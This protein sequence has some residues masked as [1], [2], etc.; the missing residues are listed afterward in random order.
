MLRVEREDRLRTIYS[1]HFLVV[2]VYEGAVDSW[3]RAGVHTHVAGAINLK[4]PGEVSFSRSFADRTRNSQ[5][6]P[7]G[8]HSKTAQSAP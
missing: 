8:A 7:S 2:V 1:E 6:R 4:Q 3:C 5:H